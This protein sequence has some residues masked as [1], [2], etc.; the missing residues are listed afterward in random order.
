MHSG[1]EKPGHTI[2]VTFLFL[3]NSS[4]ANW[5]VS[6]RV[7]SSDILLQLRTIDLHSANARPRCMNFKGILVM[8]LTL[9]S[10]MCTGIHDPS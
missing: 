7:F 8:I 9:F 6:F 4:L 3:S 10:A 5:S 1:F 2:S